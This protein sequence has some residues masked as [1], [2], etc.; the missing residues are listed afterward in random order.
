MLIF[1]LLANNW[2][3]PTSAVDSVHN[4][5]MVMLASMKLQD[6]H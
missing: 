6:A 5:I 2:I 4:R 3:T 1:S